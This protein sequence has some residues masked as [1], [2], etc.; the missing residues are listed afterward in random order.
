MSLSISIY[1]SI[2][3]FFS[4][5]LSISIFFS[6]YL[7]LTLSKN[8]D[9]V[10]IFLDLRRMS[11]CAS[12]VSI[13]QKERLF[14]VQWRQVR[15]AGAEHAREGADG[16]PPSGQ[17]QEG[18]SLGSGSGL[19]AEQHSRQG[20]CQG[21]R[22]PALCKSLA[23]FS[24]RSAAKSLFRVLSD[25]KSHT[26]WVWTTAPFSRRWRN[27]SFKTEEAESLQSLRFR[28]EYT[29]KQQRDS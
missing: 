26:S 27:S 21:H 9:N 20:H 13:W 24:Q 15:L 1:L 14:S 23:R 10:L 22:R 16:A 25:T 29:T 6:P 7:S 4:L 18:Q 5:Y 11:R 17:P 3:I 19:G 8:A 12:V 28:C 2:S